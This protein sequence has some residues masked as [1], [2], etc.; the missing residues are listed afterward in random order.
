MNDGIV[1][2]DAGRFDTFRS[3]TPDDG[4]TTDPGVLMR[5][6]ALLAAD[7]YVDFSVFDENSDGRIPND[8]LLVVLIRPSEWVPERR[9]WA[10]CAGTG[11]ADLN[12]PMDG[13]QVRFNVAIAGTATNVLSI[14]HEIGHAAF[15]MLDYRRQIGARTPWALG[16]GTCGSALGP[17]TPGSPPL[18]WQ[19]CG[20]E[21]IHW[22]WVCPKVVTTDGFYSIRPYGSTGDTYLLYDAARGANEFALVSNR[23]RRFPYEPTAP[24]GL[25]VE[26]V[27]EARWNTPTPALDMFTPDANARSVPIV[28]R[29]GS[30]S[31]LAIRDIGQDSDIRCVFFDVPGPGLFV[32]RAEHGRAEDNPV[33]ARPGETFI[34]RFRVMNTHDEGTVPSN[35]VFSVKTAPGSGWRVSTTEMT[36]APKQESFA[37]VAV[38][39]S[40]TAVVDQKY[41]LTP[42]GQ[43]LDGTNTTEAFEA[44]SVLVTND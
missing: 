16:N 30:E 36:L 9:T 35:F 14:A 31:R 43:S 23:R 20:W 41:S 34:A 28:W 13:V 24:D 27:D 33:Y 42:F 5:R 32:G 2:V 6:H 37:S 10:N 7:R 17:G 22:G 40:S 25:V 44:F 39:V 1:F 3:P 15:D 11:S 19:P 29:D 4:E 26:V 12:T 18:W 21:K 38:T 8:E